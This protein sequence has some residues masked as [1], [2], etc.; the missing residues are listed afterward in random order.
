MKKHIGVIAFFMMLT[1]LASSSTF[2]KDEPLTVSITPLSKLLINAKSSAPANI[3]SLNNSTISAEITGR[4]LKIQAE[5]GDYVKKGQKLVALD[6]R[7]YSLAKKQAQ[8]GL[9]VAK[10]QLNFSDK[11]FKRNQNL[12]KKGIIPREIFEKAEASKLTALADIQLKKANIETAKLA[13]SR[14]QIS[15]PFSGQIIKRLVQEGQ[16]VSTGTPL[17]QLMQSNKLEIRTNLSP[18]DVAKLD[19]TP[20]LKFVAGKLQLNAEVRSV[21]QNIDEAT[22]TQEVRL[23]LPP[24][25]QVAVGLS[26]RIEWSSKAK[27][28]PAEYLIRRNS[29]LGVIVAEDIVEGI[30]RARF[31]QIVGAKEGQAV[32]VDL[33]ENTAVITQNQFRLKTGQSIKIK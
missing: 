2:A 10:T 12:I 20:V 11:Q 21:I 14:C 28:L 22:R 1:F 33:P 19:D 29:I 30:G 31:L 26:G 6:C 8:A 18:A 15:A 17:F 7:S 27:L 25:T 13:I 32:E 3:I 16:L 24:D 9:K 23:S 5:T 4:A